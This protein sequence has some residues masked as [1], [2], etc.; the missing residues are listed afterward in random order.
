V[1]AFRIES[2][3][4]TGPNPGARDGVMEEPA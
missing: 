3:D 4:V 1:L 2:D